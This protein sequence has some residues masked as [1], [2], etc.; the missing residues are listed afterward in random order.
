MPSIFLLPVV[1]N[2][3]NAALGGMIGFQFTADEGRSM[4]ILFCSMVELGCGLFSGMCAPWPCSPALYARAANQMR[5]R[6][7]CMGQ[8]RH[9][10]LMTS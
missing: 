7:V 1:A 2:V 3:V 9:A 6:G 8:P 10:R 4:W 5:K